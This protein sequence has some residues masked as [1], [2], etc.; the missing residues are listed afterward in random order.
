MKDIKRIVTYS[1]TITT[2][3]GM[4]LSHYSYPSFTV[5][6]C[7]TSTTQADCLQI[8]PYVSQ[9]SRGLLP[10]GCP[11]PYNVFFRPLIYSIRCMCPNRHSLPAFILD[12]ISDS[13]NRSA[14]S[15]FYLIL[16]PSSDHAG[17]NIFLRFFSLPP[18]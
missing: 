17:P 12:R 1:L 16:K 7:R 11:Y 10:P 14:T 4:S 18:V 5:S 9:P 8:V 6:C 2:M 15:W 3:K 13:F